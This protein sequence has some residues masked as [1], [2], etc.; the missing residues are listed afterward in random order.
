MQNLHE[1]VAAT[2][3][4]GLMSGVG[5]FEPR[6]W[7]K[8]SGRRLEP[9]DVVWMGNGC[10]VLFYCAH[11]SSAGTPDRQAARYASS[12][13][14]NLRQAKRSIRYW[15]DSGQVL[16]GENPHFKFHLSYSPHR[17]IVVIS[18]VDVGVPLARH[19]GLLDPDLPIA[20]CVTMP[21]RFLD[22][23]LRSGAALFDFVTVLERVEDSPRHELRYDEFDNLATAIEHSIHSHQTAGLWGSDLQARNTHEMFKYW[24]SAVAGLRTAYSPEKGLF[25]GDARFGP[26][27]TSLWDILGIV[28]ELERAYRVVKPHSLEPVSPFASGVYRGRFTDHGIFVAPSFTTPLWRPRAIAASKSWS[29]QRKNGTLRQ[30]FDLQVGVQELPGTMPFVVAIDDTNSSIVAS[31][32]LDRLAERLAGT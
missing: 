27:D 29:D 24:F 3:C 7:V 13:E 25:D 19:H 26:L 10:C 1:A 30:G 14:H 18:V 22:R 17:P 9:A 4:R 28:A 23:M 8:P 11:S 2:L 12:I 5:V 6:E 15:R 32:L 16:S 20:H 21:L 31:R